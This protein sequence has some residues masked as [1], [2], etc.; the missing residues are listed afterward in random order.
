MIQA[1]DR[2]ATA[3]GPK[4]VTDGGHRAAWGEVLLARGPWDGVVVGRT[5]LGIDRT[6]RWGQASRLGSDLSM[7]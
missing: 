6:E 3:T 4:V 2:A 1:G 7:S 5:V